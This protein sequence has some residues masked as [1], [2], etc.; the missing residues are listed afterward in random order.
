MT[1]VA[2]TQVRVVLVDATKYQTKTY[3][4]PLKKANFDVWYRGMRAFA[5]LLK[6]GIQMLEVNNQFWLDNPDLVEGVCC[7]KI[8]SLGNIVR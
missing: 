5:W 4:S 1:Q 7:G 2:Q 3:Q 6:S 8:K